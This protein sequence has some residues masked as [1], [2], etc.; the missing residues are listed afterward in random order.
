MITKEIEVLTDKY[1]NQMTNLSIANAVL[2]TIIEAMECSA[3]DIAP[4][5]GALTLFKMVYK[6]ED[7]I[8]ESITRLQ[9]EEA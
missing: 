6:M 9:R 4:L 8:Y 1:N 2:D 5:E 7:D 3:T